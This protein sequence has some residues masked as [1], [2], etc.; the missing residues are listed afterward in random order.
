MTD[1]IDE[2]EI[3]LRVWLECAY[4]RH[5]HILHPGLINAQISSQNN[6]SYTHSIVYL[7]NPLQ[8]LILR[9]LSSVRIEA[10]MIVVRVVINVS[11]N[12][13]QVSLL[14]KCR[15]CAVLV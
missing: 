1:W 13:L 8:T 6:I 11:E 10:V 15:W 14:Y 9:L 5:Y 7:Y 3:V 4:P 12:R 2:C